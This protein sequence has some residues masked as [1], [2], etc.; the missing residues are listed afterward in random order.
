M[1]HCNSNDN[2]FDDLIDNRQRNKIP[3]FLCHADDIQLHF[4]VN[5][6]VQ[7]RDVALKLFLPYL[8]S[9]VFLKLWRIIPVQERRSCLLSFKDSLSLLLVIQVPTKSFL[10]TLF[11]MTSRPITTYPLFSSF[12]E[13]LQ[14][15]QF[16]LKKKP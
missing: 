8:Y 15:H 2:C 11:L 7:L 13:S 3:V 4:L 6:C 12:Q 16:I 5:I 10:P 9:G 14:S 1:I